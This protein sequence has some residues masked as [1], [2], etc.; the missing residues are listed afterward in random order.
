MFATLDPTS[1]R[2]RLPIEQEIIINDTV[3]FIRDLPPA[4]IAAF[5]ATLEEITD[6]DLLLHVVDAANPR[7]LQHIESVERILSELQ[8]NDIPR[9]I[10]LNK[11]DLLEEFEAEALLRQISI[12]KQTECV[13]ISALK[14]ESL[15]TL[16]EKIGEKLSRKIDDNE[17]DNKNA[18]FTQQEELSE[19]ALT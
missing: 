16:L 12:E 19:F 2:L 13:A 15:R 5:R 17:T 10:V 4:L 1:R 8:L 14:T 3:G 11:S 9:L 7:C 6:S 18:D